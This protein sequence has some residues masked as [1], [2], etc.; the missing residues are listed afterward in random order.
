MCCCSAS[1]HSK[2]G[3]QCC[4]WRKLAARPFNLTIDL[5]LPTR[6][7]QAPRRMMFKNFDQTYRYSELC[8]FWMFPQLVRFSHLGGVIFAFPPS[9]AVPFIEIR[10]T[11][12]PCSLDISHFRGIYPPDHS[13]R[14]VISISGESESSIVLTWM[15]RDIATNRQCWYFTQPGLAKELLG[16]C[17]TCS[18]DERMG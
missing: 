3:H 8:P 14:A 2:F 11:Y 5:E 6:Y 15:C 13:R 12:V 10:D 17:R 18:G 9:N 1:P 4:L 7:R 16:C